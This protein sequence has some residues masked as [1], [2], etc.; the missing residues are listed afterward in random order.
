M[1]DSDALHHVWFALGPVEITGAIVMTWIV[2]AALGLVGFV[3]TRALKIEPGPFQTMLEGIVLALENAV[4]DVVP[5]HRRMVM[6][7]VATL[8]VFII[9]AN[10]LGLIPGLDSP[11]ADFSVTSSLAILVFLS[12]HWFGLRASGPK[13]Y[14]KHYLA[15]SPLMLPFH[16]IGEV[17]RT[18]A[19]AIRLFGNMMSMEMAAL[20]ML[21]AA[22]FLAP[23]PILMLHIV[24]ALVQ[25]YIFGALALVYIAGGIVVQ[26]ARQPTENS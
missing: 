9:A 11:T 25:A 20:I 2:M 12:V 10:L 21:S 26:E 18:V 22:A 16:V 1:T 17:T 14:F 23:V 13:A 15:P 6:P 19:M 7:F 5:Q 8:W 4:G 24:E 3:A